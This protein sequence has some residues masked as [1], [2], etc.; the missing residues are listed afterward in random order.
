RTKRHQLYSLRLQG[1]RCAFQPVHDCDDLLDRCAVGAHRFYGLHDGAAFGRD[2]LDE[3]N[4][5]VGA[6]IAVDL[7]LRPVVL[8]F[9]A[10]H[11]PVDPALLETAHAYGRGDRHG[12]ELEPADRFDACV[13]TDQPKYE[14]GNQVQAFG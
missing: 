10:H 11:E 13:V 3:N 12:A 6:E 5:A 9:L 8:G 1:G 14:I 2:V 7:L 4:V